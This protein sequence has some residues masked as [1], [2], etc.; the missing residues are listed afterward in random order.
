MVNYRLSRK[1]KHVYKQSSLNT[2]QSRLNTKQ[3]SLNTKQSSNVLNILKNKNNLIKKQTTIYKVCN[4]LNTKKQD[5]LKGIQLYNR[6]SIPQV[7][8]NL[9]CSNQK[10][11]CNLCNEMFRCS[12]IIDHIRPLF[13]G[14][15]NNLSNYQGLCD[16]CNKIKTDVIDKKIYKSFINDEIKEKDLTT[17]YIISKQKNYFESKEYDLYI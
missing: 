8:K 12:I 3:S 2:K 7:E 9:I 14:G 13:M 6:E 11:R 16:I 15:T 4:K 5:T 17:E 10:W 1:C